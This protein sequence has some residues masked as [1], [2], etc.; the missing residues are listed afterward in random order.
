MEMEMG[1]RMEMGIRIQI[2]IHVEMRMWA[3]AASRED[4]SPGPVLL[5]FQSE[6]CPCHCCTELHILSTT[7]I[8]E[9]PS[10]TPGDVQDIPT[11]NHQ[12]RPEPSWHMCPA[13]CCVGSRAAEG[14][15][16]TVSG[17]GRLLPMPALAI[18]PVGSLCSPS[19]SSLT[20]WFCSCCVG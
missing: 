11:S 8:P 15:P 20:K 9:T 4:S 14:G 12:C 13:A 7:L 6:G 17:W 1:V 16:T 5:L 10:P 3:T 19:N 2:E 18:C